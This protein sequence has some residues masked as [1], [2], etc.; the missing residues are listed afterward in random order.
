MF[1]WFS[2][3]SKEH[4]NVNTHL[5]M[6]VQLVVLSL[7]DCT[8]RFVFL[9]R[10]HPAARLEL[11]HWKEHNSGV[12][13]ILVSLSW[14]H[15]QRDLYFFRYVFASVCVCTNYVGALW[16]CSSYRR[17]YLRNVL[18]CSSCSYDWLLSVREMHD[19][20]G[21]TVSIPPISSVGS[22]NSPQLWEIFGAHVGLS[23]VRR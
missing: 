18:Q 7:W 19:I 2:S 1:P 21:V 20:S 10:Y 5:V 16:C 9:I 6:P 12:H 4:A 3:V 17:L 22:F 14:S 15:W 13:I 8:A 11:Q 23:L